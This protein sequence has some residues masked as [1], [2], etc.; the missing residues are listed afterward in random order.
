MPEPLI[1]KCP[2][3]EGTLDID[4]QTGEIV[5]KWKAGEKAAPAAERFKEAI[6][7]LEQEKKTREARFQEAQT[8]L[9]GK[10]KK[11]EEAFEKEVKKAK[12]EGPAKPPHPL[13]WE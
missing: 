13:D 9:K 7:K 8:L 3:C 6:Q 1:V 10:K 2:F 5:R 12:E 11:I 4:R